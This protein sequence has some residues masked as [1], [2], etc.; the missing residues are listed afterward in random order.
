MLISPG[1][2]FTSQQLKLNPLDYEAN[3]IAKKRIKKVAR[4]RER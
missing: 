4:R 1:A 3:A 2:T